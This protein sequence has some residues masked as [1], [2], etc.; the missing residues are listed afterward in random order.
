MVDGDA[1]DH[2]T[3]RLQ[4]GAL[5]VGE[6]HGQVAEIDLLVDVIAEQTQPVLVAME[7]LPASAQGELDG[8]LAADSFSEAAWLAI[9]GERYWPAPLHVREYVRVAEAAWKRSR[10]GVDVRLIGLAPD[11]R[12]GPLPDSR[13]AIACFRDRDDAM[14]RVLREVRASHP[15]HRLVVSA[16]WRHLSAVR[17]PSAPKVMGESWPAHW[18]ATRVLLTAP[19]RAAEAGGWV[20]TCGAGPSALAEARNGPVVVDLAH[21][22]AAG[23]TLGGCVDLPKADTRSLSKA[24]D[25]LVA[26]PPGAPPTPLDEDAFQLVDPSDRAAWVRTR[27]E[28]MGQADAP[29]SPTAWASWARE[30][31]DGLRAQLQA[32][33]GCPT[34]LP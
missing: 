13:T 21:E 31:V 12:L 14:L 29:T 20:S 1:V 8:M 30:D 4:S 19:E 33:E 32:V 18:P 15:Q 17:L 24:F 22:S 7:L 27:R 16:G 10:D 34:T 25:L 2:L 5:L 28:L 9:V 6:H 26:L 23:L 3:S 11:C